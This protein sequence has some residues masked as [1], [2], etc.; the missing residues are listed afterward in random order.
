MALSDVEIWA[1]LTNGRL[2]ITPDPGARVGP[3]SVDLLLG[4]ELLILPSPEEVK[5]ITV[6]PRT[7]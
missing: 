3:S 6:S 2:V 1:E 7:S 5:G 4:P